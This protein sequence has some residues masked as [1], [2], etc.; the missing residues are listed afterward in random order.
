MRAT[1]IHY[2]GEQATLL[3]K[4]CAKARAK[5]LNQRRRIGWEDHTYPYGGCDECEDCESGAA[6]LAGGGKRTSACGPREPKE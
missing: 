2:D 3:C 4:R 6:S 1:L 5:G